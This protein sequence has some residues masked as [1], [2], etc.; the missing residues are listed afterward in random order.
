MRPDSRRSASLRPPM[1]WLTSASATARFLASQNDLRGRNAL[2][3]GSRALH[4]EIA[5]AGLDLIPPD[6]ARQAEV[7]VVGGHEG[8]DYDELRAATTAIA[9]GAALFATGRDAVFP[10]RTDQR[11]RRGR[12]SPQS[13]QRRG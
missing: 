6:E 8:F 10:T 7:V 11:R 9:T 1:M 12:S 4:E 2:V 3:I 5:K 13:R